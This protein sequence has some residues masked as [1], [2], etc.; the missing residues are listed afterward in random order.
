M[1]IEVASKGLVVLF[2]EPVAPRAARLLRE[3][4][5]RIE[6]FRS[7]QLTE[8]DLL[9]ADLVLTLTRELAEQIKETFSVQA[10]C[11]SIG[12][13]IDIEEEIP[14]VTEEDP[15]TYQKCFNTLEQLMEAVADRIIGEF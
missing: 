1:D 9:S 11:M 6:E 3:E 5:Y 10:S 12:T 13:F 8:E 2:S 15:E 7:S 4:G 14:E